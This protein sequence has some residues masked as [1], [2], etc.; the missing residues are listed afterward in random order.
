M[1]F[2]YILEVVFIT[3]C[4]T[5]AYLGSDCLTRRAENIINGVIYTGK[6]SAVVHFGN[7]YALEE[8]EHTPR[9]IFGFLSPESQKYSIDVLA[10]KL[11]AKGTMPINLNLK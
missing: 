5:T 3:F 2:S 6:V 11:E 8:L 9:S 7:P 4:N 10:G 1:S